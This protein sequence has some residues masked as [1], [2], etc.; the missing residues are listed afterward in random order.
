MPHQQSHQNG[1]NDTLD[2]ALAAAPR[3][4]RLLWRP[5]TLV[6]IQAS[7]TGGAASVSSEVER[8]NHTSMSTTTFF[9]PS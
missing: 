5:P 7:H 1:D 8:T 2:H 4:P 6:L 9:G 3:P